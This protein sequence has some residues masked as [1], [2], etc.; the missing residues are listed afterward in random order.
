M[1]TFHVSLFTLL[2]LTACKRSPSPA[3]T[4]PASP[5]IVALS[6][7]AAVT[8]QDLGLAPSIVGRHAYD[9]VLDPALPS[10]GD[11]LGLDFENLLRVH[12]THIIIQWG[13]RD[14]PARLTQLAAEHA[15]TITAYDPL[16]LADLRADTQRLARMFAS[17]PGFDT[18]K[19]A[20]L[21]AEFD[22][23]FA[24][25]TPDLS[26][27]GKVLLLWSASPPAALGPGSWHH[28]IL[29]AI[30]GTPAITEGAASISLDQ[31]DALRL[32]PDAIVLIIP[33]DPDAKLTT[34]ATQPRTPMDAEIR[35]KLL[36]PLAKLDLPANR[37]NH[38]ALIDD[39]L[40]HTPSTAMIHFADELAK[41]L[42]AWA[43]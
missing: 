39:P 43:K 9:M 21:T 36:G 17:V 13:K 22:R 16:T 30:G 20:R 3:P 1:L 27:A 37:S 18:S 28:Q 41:V 2:L 4:P 33:H 35:A 10:C 42:G 38:V 14:L 8:L 25:R 34:S 26:R 12:P 19:A 7:G 24:K 32:A 6:P 5:R 23:A 15:W 11:Q 40:A 29:T 31:E